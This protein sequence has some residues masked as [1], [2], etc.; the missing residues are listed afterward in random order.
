MV[1]SVRRFQVTY[2][3]NVNRVLGE[4]TQVHNRQLS[5][6]SARTEHMPIGRYSGSTAGTLA[7]VLRHVEE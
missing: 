1:L 5:D 6:L 2:K 3:R 4:Q 7:N